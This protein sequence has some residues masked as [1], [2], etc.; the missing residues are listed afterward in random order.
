MGRLYYH[1]SI[2]VNAY[3]KTTLQ[4]EGAHIMLSEKVE[5]GIVGAR[6]N[7]RNP[8]HNNKTQQHIYRACS[9]QKYRYFIRVDWKEIRALFCVLC[10]FQVFLIPTSTPQSYVNLWRVHTV[11]KAW[12]LARRI[13]SYWPARFLCFLM[14]MFSCAWPGQQTH[15]APPFSRFAILS[16]SMFSVCGFVGIFPPV[17]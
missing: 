2:K 7:K 6:L 15:L 13:F 4:W 14:G 10:C 12:E 9:T 11:G 1:T 8:H 17:G 5:H 16:S 3:I